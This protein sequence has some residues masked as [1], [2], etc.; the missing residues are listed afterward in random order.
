MWFL[1]LSSCL[2]KGRGKEANYFLVVSFHRDLSDTA[3]TGLSHGQ[4]HSN[5]C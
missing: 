3:G 2:L 5:G 1:I 4:G